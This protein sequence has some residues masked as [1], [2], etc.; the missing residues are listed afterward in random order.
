MAIVQLEFPDFEE[1]EPNDL[2]DIFA[3]KLH[4]KFLQMLDD[5][6][7]RDEDELIKEGLHNL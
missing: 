5:Y 4:R 7:F 3:K 1:E 6:V 2:A